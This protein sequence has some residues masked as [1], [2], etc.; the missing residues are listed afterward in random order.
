VLLASSLLEASEEAAGR[1][2]E[3]VEVEWLGALIR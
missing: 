2:L 3:T 1:G